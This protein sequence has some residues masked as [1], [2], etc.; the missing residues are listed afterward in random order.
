[1]GPLPFLFPGVQGPDP[2]API[3]DIRQKWWGEGMGGARA[4]AVMLLVLFSNK[5]KSN[6]I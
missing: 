6:V 2:E 4:Q 5:I 3:T 1:M